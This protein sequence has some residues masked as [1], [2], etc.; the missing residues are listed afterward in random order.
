MRAAA[1][2][3]LTPVTSLLRTWVSADAAADFA[4]LLARGLRR[5]FP[6]ADA[7]RL[8]VLSRRLPA[9]ID[10]LSMNR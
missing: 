3:V 2:A 9:M 4:A 10:L 8:P 5:V 1:E 7:A 6:A